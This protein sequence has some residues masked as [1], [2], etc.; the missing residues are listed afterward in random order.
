[1]SCSSYSMYLD[2]VQFYFQNYIQSLKAV[3]QS[4]YGS[5]GR[6]WCVA[7][8]VWYKSLTSSVFYTVLDRFHRNFVQVM[9]VNVSNTFLVRHGIMELGAL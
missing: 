1:M 7:K 6:G 3:Y 2:W 8:H 9:V 4:S 5:D